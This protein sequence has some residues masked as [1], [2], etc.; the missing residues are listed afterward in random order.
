MIGMRLTVLLHKFAAVVM[1]GVSSFILTVAERKSLIKSVA[2]A[3]MIAGNC[4]IDVKNVTEMGRLNY[5][6]T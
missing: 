1:A 3:V 2:I 5:E 4:G 6:F